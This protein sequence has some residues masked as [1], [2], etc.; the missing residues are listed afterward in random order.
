MHKPIWSLLE[1]NHCA[2]AHLWH[3]LILHGPLEFRLWLIIKDGFY[4]S[5]HLLFYLISLWSVW[6]ANFEL[7]VFI[8]CVSPWLWLHASNYSFANWFTCLGRRISLWLRIGQLWCPLPMTSYIYIVQR[9][10]SFFLSLVPKFL[11][12]SLWS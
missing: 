1:S 12:L 11:E 6:D 3:L 4:Y 2:H 8:I 10:S 5:R 7:I 9:H